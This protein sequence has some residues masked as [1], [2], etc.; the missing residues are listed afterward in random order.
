M[1]AINSSNI[2]GVI[3]PVPESDVDLTQPGHQI[4]GLLAF[5]QTAAY[6]EENESCPTSLSAGRGQYVPLIAM[7]GN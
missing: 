7:S 2:Q 1:G 3:E 5:C 6:F 4:G